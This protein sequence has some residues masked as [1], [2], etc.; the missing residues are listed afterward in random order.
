MEPGRALKPRDVTS[1]GLWVS[2]VWLSASSGLAES[3]PVGYLLPVA[4]SDGHCECVLPSSRV[5]EKYFL[6]VGSL[7]QD[8]A[9]RRVTLRTAATSSLL[10]IPLENSPKSAEWVKRNEDLKKRLEKARQNHPLTHEYRPL[11]DPPRHKSFHLLVKEGDLQD[12]SNYAEIPADLGAVGRH[13]LVYVEHE[14]V[15]LKGLKATIQDAVAAFDREIYPQAR[16]RLGQALDV[17]RDGRFTILF[18]S[19]LGKLS[20]GKAKLD[21]FV[22]GSDFYRDLDPP[23]GNQCD[24]MYLAADLKPGPYL[25]TLLAHEY[26]H[27]IVFSEHVFGS[28]LPGNDEEGW[29]NEALAHLNEDLHGYTWENLDYRISAFLVEP[30]RYSVV[31]PDYFGARLWRSHGHRGATYLFLRWCV[32]H[33]GQD[34]LRR[35]VQSNLSGVT[36]LEVATGERFGDLFRQ[37]A[38]SLLV[39]GTK[40]PLEGVSPFRGFDLH[41]PLGGRLLSGPR[42]ESVRMDKEERTIALAGT[43]VAY[44]LLHSPAGE[45]TRLTVNAEEGMDLQVSLIR[46]PA[47]TGRLNVAWDD[48][49]EPRLLL[50][51]NDC[52]MRIDGL[53]WERVPPMINSSADTSFRADTPMDQTVRTWLGD[54]RL[55][56][57][58]TR[59][60]ATLSLP[61]PKNAQEKIVIKITGTDAAGHHLSAWI[62]R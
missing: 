43:S 58:E 29:L 36:N 7:N 13:C 3:P 32:E 21:G 46:L 27:A 6:I 35:L 17:D 50:T 56:S 44:F 34:L 8:L 49:K 55:R 42:V 39:S 60:S 59:R 20:G 4:S 47:S 41:Q 23:L 26:T 62:D 10:S 38:A 11:A 22:R 53:A 12:P 40:L 30:A 54:P 25:H 51:A 48:A 16:T 24:M 1:L 52:D 31:V 33:S 57:G 45:R 2:L 19:R 18:T 28:Y 9:N 61:K 14:N 37:W 5:D 15:D